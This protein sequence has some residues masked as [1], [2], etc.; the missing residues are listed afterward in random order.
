M[1]SNMNYSAFNE[2]G[3][4]VILNCNI[5]SRDDLIYRSNKSPFIWDPVTLYT[6]F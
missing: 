5:P 2:A 6:K 1:K 3:E 4:E